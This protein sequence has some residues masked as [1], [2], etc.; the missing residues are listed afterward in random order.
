M[1]W[2]LEKTLL[3]GGIYRGILAH[4]GRAKVPVPELE[5][6]HDGA[7]IEL[8][9]SPIEGTAN[10]HEVAVTL[11]ARL[12]SD[13]VNTV[14]LSIRGETTPLASFAVIGGDAVP[15][16]LAQDVALLRAELDMLKRMVRRTARDA[17]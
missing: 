1:A 10:Q 4:K 15:D 5:A 17:D 12:I 16:D 6:T 13:G 3:K 11:P 9:V 2:T 8:T 7:E 14:V